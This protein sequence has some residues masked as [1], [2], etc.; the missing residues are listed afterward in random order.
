MSVFFY[1]QPKNGKLYTTRPTRYID[2]FIEK[3]RALIASP[4]DETEKFNTIVEAFEQLNL[5]RSDIVNSQGD[6]IDAFV[7]K[8]EEISDPNSGTLLSL[9]R[10]LYNTNDEGLFYRNFTDPAQRFRQFLTGATGAASQSQT[11]AFTGRKLGTNSLLQADALAEDMEKVNHT[12]GRDFNTAEDMWLKKKN[13]E[14]EE[15]EEINLKN[16]MGHVR[17]SSVSDD[18]LNYAGPMSQEEEIK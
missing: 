4:T 10:T 17:I 5:E 11:S 12:K 7:Q 9:A 15:A 2:M 6:A 8:I 14:S 18:I 3:M 1:I 13:K 16:L